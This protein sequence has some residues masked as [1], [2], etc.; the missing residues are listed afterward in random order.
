EGSAYSLTL[1]AVTDPGTD[2]VA[3][4]LVHW[5]DG[6]SDTYHSTGVKTHTYADGPSNHPITVDLTDEDGSFL[7]AANALSVDVNNVAP[8]VALDPGNTLTWDESTTAER[9]F[10]YSTFDPAGANDPLTITIDCGPGGSYV[11]GSD[12]G[13]SFKCIF[14]DGPASPTVSVSA[15]D[16]DGGAGSDTQ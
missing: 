15:D 7:N 14:A 2:T 5:G 13:T 6:Q 1:G 8:T 4:Y 3:D 16:G 9:T 12:T 10:L 11:D